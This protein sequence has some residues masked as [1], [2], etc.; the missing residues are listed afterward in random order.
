MRE[1]GTIRWYNHTREFGF[2]GRD[3]AEDLYLNPART[4]RRCLGRSWNR[5]GGLSR[6]Q[7]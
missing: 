2:I 1:T 6:R 7:R 4:A 5:Y 3:G